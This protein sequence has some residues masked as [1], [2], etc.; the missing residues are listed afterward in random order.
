MTTTFFRVL[1][2]IPNDDG[3]VNKNSTRRLWGR[4]EWLAT[5]K[6]CP[7]KWIDKWNAGNR[8]I[9]SFTTDDLDCSDGL[10]TRAALETFLKA[11]SDHGV[12]G[13]VPWPEEVL[14]KV[15]QID[16]VFAYE[17]PKEAWQYVLGDGGTV[18]SEILGMNWIVEFP[19]VNTDHKIPESQKGGVQ[20]R[21]L[22]AG[23]ARTAEEFA[24]S[25]NYH[26]PLDDSGGEIDLEIPGGEFDPNNP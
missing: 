19:G 3:T 8:T 7:K 26:I 16:G 21:V 10:R 9:E 17:T 23:I 25:H 1:E 20:V 4:S 18:T 5:H 12:D 13:E 24:Y 14:V 22:D 2:D 15:G 11:A 6:A